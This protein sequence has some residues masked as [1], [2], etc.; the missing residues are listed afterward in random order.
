M[1]LD[2][3]IAEAEPAIVKL[4]KDWRPKLMANYGTAQFDLKADKSVVTKFDKELELELKGVLKPLSQEVGFL[5]EEHGQEGSKEI[6]W[7]IDPIDGTESFLRGYQVARN[8]LAL[9]V[10]GQ[11]EYALCY[12]FPVDAMYIARRGQGTTKNGQQI[13]IN[14]KPLE[15]CWIN[16]AADLSDPKIYEAYKRLRPLIADFAY[17]HNYLVTVEGIM[18]AYISSFMGGPWDYVPIA[19]LM[20]EAGARVGNYGSLNYDLNIMGLVAAHPDNFETI[21]KLLSSEP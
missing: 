15:R 10:K 6:Y 5:G 19:L 7:T 21:Q 20:Q 3:Y 12:Q 8:Q 4:L 17:P 13:K 9:V 18:D 1:D 14:Y 11:A 2:A 16:I